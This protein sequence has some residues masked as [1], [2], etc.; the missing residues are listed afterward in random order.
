MKAIPRTE[1]DEEEERGD[2]DDGGGRERG[3]GL[4]A[5]GDRVEEGP[6]Q[7]EGPRE[8]KGR[9]H[10]VPVPLLPAKL[11]VQP[12]GDQAVHPGGEHV[13]QDEGRQHRAC[14]QSV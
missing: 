9:R 13:D 6:H 2:D 11:P 3:R 5:P 10:D 14:F 8:H 7:S 12:R 1:G 4:V